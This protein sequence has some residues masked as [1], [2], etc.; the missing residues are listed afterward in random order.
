MPIKVITAPTEEPVTP[1]EAKLHLRVDGTDDDALITALIVAAREAA[2]HI[3]GRALMP[4]T[5]ELALDAFY[6]FNRDHPGRHAYRVIL[7]RPPVASITSVKYVDT[8]GTLQT[9]DP[10]AYV[11]DDYSEPARLVP[12]YGTCW[13]ATRCQENA[14]L[15]QYE[16]GYADAASVPQQIKSWMLLRIG[17]LYEN[18]EGIVAGVP[19]AEMPGVDRLLDACRVWGA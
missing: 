9:L 3:T 1:G 11:L 19:L 8:T 15:I 13:P 12:A 14:V 6:E 7:P 17:M 4:Q 2:E 16:A 5:L 18:R 10:S